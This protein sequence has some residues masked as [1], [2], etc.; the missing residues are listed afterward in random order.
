MAGQNFPIDTPASEI[1]NWN[2]REV[3]YSTDW[4]NGETYLSQ[5][6]FEEFEKRIALSIERL[7]PVGT[8]YWSASAANP[9]TVLGFGTWQRITDTFIYAAT[10]E[11]MAL[12]NTKKDYTGGSKTVKITNANLPQY[13]TSTSQEIIN[14]KLDKNIHYGQGNADQGSGFFRD[15][16]AIHY[17]NNNV[18]EVKI[19]PPYK[20]AYCWQRIA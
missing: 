17:N 3:L 9:G 5:A 4:K 10:D 8:L 13:T 16:V 11:Q 6:T 14:R 20:L 18:S 1:A 19:M 15:E 12:A 7:Y 2:T